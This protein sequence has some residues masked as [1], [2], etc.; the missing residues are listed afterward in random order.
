[1]AYSKTTW[2]NGTT[3]A[4]S[5]ANLNKMEQGIA[6]GVNGETQNHKNIQTEDYNAFGSG[7]TGHVDISDLF[8]ISGYYINQSGNP[9]ANSGSFCSDFIRVIP[10]EEYS[11]ALSEYLGG[12][13]GVC[14]YD[15]TQTF[16]SGTHIASTGYTNT[17]GTFTVPSGVSYMRVSSIATLHLLYKKTNVPTKNVVGDI[18][19]AIGDIYGNYNDI[20]DSLISGGTRGKYLIANTGAAQGSASETSPYFLTDY[21]PVNEGDI[22]SFYLLRQYSSNAIY[23]LYDKNKTF[24]SSYQGNNGTATSGTLTIPVQIAYVRFSSMDYPSVFTVKKKIIVP[25]LKQIQDINNALDGF[26]INTD[27][28][29]EVSVTMIG[30]FLNSNNTITPSD[31]YIHTDYI[32]ITKYNWLAGSVFYGYNAVA[33]LL[34]DDTK[35]VLAYKSHSGGSIKETIKLVTSEVLEDYPTAK[36][37]KFSGNTNLKI[38]SGKFTDDVEFTDAILSNGNILYKKKIAFCGDSFTAGTNLGNSNKD[39]YWNCYKTYAWFI[40]DRNNM[41]FYNDGVSG[42][43]MHITNASSPSTNSPFAYQRYKDVPEDCDYIILQFGLNESTIAND[44]ETLGTRESTDPTTMWGSWNVV[45]EYLIENHPTAKIG[46]IMPDGWMIQSYFDALKEICEWWGIP[47]LDLGG[48]PNVSLMNGGRR[49]GS[50]LELNPVAKNLRNAAFATTY[51]PETHEAD[52]HPNLAGH[53]WR[54]T[55]IEHWIRS[56]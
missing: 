18:K 34:Y 56:L 47:L 45:L 13:Y 20:S 52:L 9:V 38:Y 26:E 3:P 1:M 33:Y 19:E 29:T 41:D 46:V 4:I 12:Q 7:Q 25:I 28:H 15:E 37:I 2:V 48:D 35:S 17:R 49:T 22:F 30:G 16:V 54:S 14:Y 8:N 11:I 6:V 10:G 40:V 32:D 43:T 50:G 39:F 55:V 21:I 51:D 53:K 36:Y 23:A 31:D 5:A 42:S 44:P 24:V 27:L